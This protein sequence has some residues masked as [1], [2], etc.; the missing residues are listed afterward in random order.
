MLIFLDFT[1]AFVVDMTEL[2]QSSGRRM[3]VERQLLRMP[4]MCSA[5]PKGDTVIQELLA[6][7][8]CLRQFHSYLQ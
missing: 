6:V 2:M 4:V 1:K 5:K 8:K 7:V 3:M